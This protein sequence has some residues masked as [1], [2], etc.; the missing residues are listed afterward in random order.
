MLRYGKGTLLST[1]LT[2]LM[3]LSLLTAGCGNAAQT[4]ST[5]VSVKAMK[6]LQQDTAVSHDYSGQI[7]S[8]NA[9]TIKPRVSGEIVEKYFTSGAPVENG[10]A[11][12]KIDDRQ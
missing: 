6:V 7:K 10:Q 11:L 8:T 2:G 1:V 9:V 12:Y 5:A 3:A 4:K